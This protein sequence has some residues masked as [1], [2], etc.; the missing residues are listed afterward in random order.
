MADWAI[1]LLSAL[2]G[3]LT[4]GSL[5]AW[6]SVRA[7]RAAQ[8][9]LEKDELRRQRLDCLVRL[10]GLRSIIADATFMKTE[11][12]K[13]NLIFEMSRAVALCLHNQSVQNLLRDIR[14]VSSSENLVK[15][16]RAI[17]QDTYVPLHMLGDHDL[18]E[19][20]AIKNDID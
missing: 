20:F 12:D 5:S 8:T 11:Q 2:L 3:A 1:A 18:L 6:G 9:D 7:V 14:S 16:F 10:I 15:L 19:F 17:A 4:G 13:S